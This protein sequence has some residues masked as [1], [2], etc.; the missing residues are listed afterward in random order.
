[1]HKPTDIGPN[2]T[3]IATS[4]IDSKRLMQGAQAAPTTGEIDGFALEVERVRWSAEALPLGT[5]PPP[6][7][8]KGVV[9]TVLEKVEGHKATVFVDKLGERLAYERTGARLYEM[10]LAK[11]EAAHVH[12]G[13]PTRLE[14]EAIRDDELRHFAIVRDA[15]T[16]LGG[17]PTAMTPCADVAG[18][19]GQGWVQV[20]SDPRSTLTQC[21][22]VMLGAEVSDG[23]GWDLLVTLAEKLG[24][25]EMATQFRDAL[26]QEQ[27]H[28]MRVRGWLQSAVI[29]QAGAQPA[30]DSDDTAI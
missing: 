12:A 24:F 30:I 6:G 14:L 15:I 7:S 16:T 1:M 8:V 25:A 26:V 29:G 11:H 27:E 19:A 20:L 2:R 4:P 3:G 28:A 18:V 10:L 5:V 13:G 9:K 17:D 23:E 22:M 21:L